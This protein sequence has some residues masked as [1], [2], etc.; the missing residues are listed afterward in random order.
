ML[1]SSTIAA[2]TFIGGGACTYPQDNA[3]LK[4]S[5][6]AGGSTNTNGYAVKIAF[7]GT[8]PTPK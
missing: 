5:L 3:G 4:V 2:V 1:S 8:I 7:S 6:P